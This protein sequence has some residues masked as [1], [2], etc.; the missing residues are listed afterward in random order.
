MG[1]SSVIDCLFSAVLVVLP[2]GEKAH[3]DSPNFRG[4]CIVKH[5]PELFVNDLHQLIITLNRKRYEIPLPPKEGRFG[6]RYV[7][8]SERATVEKWGSIMVRFGPEK[9]V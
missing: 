1:V 7:M 2:M 9:G 4:T 5:A 6:I 8:G 3:V